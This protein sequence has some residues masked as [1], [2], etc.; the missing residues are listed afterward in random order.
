MFAD[1]IRP[2]PIGAELLPAGGARFRVWAPKRQSVRVALLSPGEAEPGHII[3]LKRD[4]EGY[5]A[6][7]S[8]TARAGDCY[9]FLLD[10]DPRGYPDPAS[11]FQPEGPHGPSQL[12]DPHSFAWSDHAWRGRSL[13]GQILYELHIGTFTRQGDYRAAMAELPELARL[14]ITLIELLPVAEFAGEFGWGY[15][16][17]QLFAPFHHYG[18][19]DDLKAFVD[20]AH[21]NGIGVILDVVYNHFGPSGNYLGAFSDQYVSTRHHTEWGEAL[22]FDGAGSAG[23]REFFIANAE[24]WIRDFHFDGLRLDA[25]QAI[26]DDSADHIVAALGRAARA[27]AGERQIVLIAENEP[28]DVRLLA[29]DG[30]GC[31]LDGLWNDDFHHAARVA[32]TGHCEFYYGDY[33][34]TPQELVSAV[35]W[36][37]LYQGQWNERKQERR[38]T[39]TRGI[40]PSA[41]VTYLQNHDQ[42]ANS[43]RGLRG[44][45]LTSPGR[46]RA[47]TAVFLLSPATPLLFQGQEFAASSPFLYFADHEVDLA[48]LVRNGRQEFLRQFKSLAG[49]EKGAE[50]FDPCARETFERSKLDLAERERHREAYQLHRD[51][52]ALRK[53]DPVFSAQR[54][55]NLYGAVL[56]AQSFLFRWLTD[57]GDDRLM[58]ANLGTDQIFS[59]AAEPLFAAPSGK[60]WELLWSSED[61]SYGGSGTALLDIRR[62]RLPGHAAI[63]LATHSEAPD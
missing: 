40:P 46:W 2:S 21:R 50:L 30:R 62:W 44:H 26:Q 35:K 32:T 6:G 52:I 22:N 42:V 27:A 17:V 48:S 29:G 45:A 15:D 11:R 49:P 61:P 9:Y 34:G 25:T 56:G 28:Q 38:G 41:L 57:A 43:A 16:G 19:P 60:S 55:D 24:Y 53:S 4:E 8:E 7:D 39:S 54:N 58:L 23:V 59:P 18:Q 37:F 47:M 33:Q 63:V 10:D 36:G 13:A 14:G 20:E 12:T 31:A 5:H 1:D 3:Q 51:L